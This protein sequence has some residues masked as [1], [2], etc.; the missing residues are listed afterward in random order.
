MERVV[1]HGMVR[2]YPIPPP[3]F[4]PK[5]NTRFVNK[6]DSPP[7]AGLFTKVAA[8]PTNH[9]KFIG[10]CGRPRC[11]GCHLHPVSKSKDKT[12]GT[13]KIKSG[14]HVVSSNYRSGQVVGDGS[15]FNFSGFSATEIVDH[16]SNNYFDYN[17]T[18][19]DY[20][21]VVHFGYN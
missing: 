11:N 4:N 13:Q 15:G 7:T 14:H 3:P 18:Y 16:L 1:R 6:F 8:K 9:S 17:D 5:P 21:Y 10:M 20:W 12:K 19:I 2:S